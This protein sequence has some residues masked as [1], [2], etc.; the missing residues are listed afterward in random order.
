MERFC[1]CLPQVAYERQTVVFAQIQGRLIAFNQALEALEVRQHHW[2]QTSFG[3]VMRRLL[4]LVICYYWLLGLYSIQCIP[5]SFP[6]CYS[7]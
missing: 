2:H 5:K 3:I 1:T 7:V 4:A 6:A